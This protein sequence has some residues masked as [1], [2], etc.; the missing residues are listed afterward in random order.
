MNNSKLINY[1][2]DTRDLNEK[3]IEWTITNILKNVE[4]KVIIN[5]LSKNE[6]DRET[7]KNIIK[8]ANIRITERLNKIN[9]ND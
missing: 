9:Y 1:V 3:W 5:I 7:I 8:T 4:L 2:N 6:F